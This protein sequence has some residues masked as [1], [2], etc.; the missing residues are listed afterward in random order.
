MIGADRTGKPPMRCLLLLHSLLTLLPGQ[1][2]RYQSCEYTFG[3]TFL[4][5]SQKFLI[6]CYKSFGCAT[7]T[8]HNIKH[9]LCRA[10]AAHVAY[11]SRP[12]LYHIQRAFSVSKLVWV[13]HFWDQHKKYLFIMKVS[14]NIYCTQNSLW[15]FFY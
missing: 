1:W 12:G 5:I 11:Y 15:I 6:A 2:D 8:R 4:I 9:V 14:W 7:I 3:A 13:P 10:V